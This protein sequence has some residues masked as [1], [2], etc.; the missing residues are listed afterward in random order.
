MNDLT[1]FMMFIFGYSRLVLQHVDDRMAGSYRC[2]GKNRLGLVQN[3][4][5][6]LI[7]GERRD[8]FK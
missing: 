3:E 5:Q 7:R 8:I 2:I 1:G 4:F 6:L